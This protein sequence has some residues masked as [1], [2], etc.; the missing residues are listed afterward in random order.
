[1]GRGLLHSPG[2]HAQQVALSVPPAYACFQRFRDLLMLFSVEACGVVPIN[3][4]KYLYS[5]EDSGHLHFA[6][7]LLFFV[8]E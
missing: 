6:V 4:Y 8:R 3:M 2:A 1:M 5:L 7:L